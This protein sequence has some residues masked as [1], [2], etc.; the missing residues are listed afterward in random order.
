MMK[1]VHKQRKEHFNENATRDNGVDGVFA[2][3]G[4]KLECEVAGVV[5][6]TLKQRRVCHQCICHEQETRRE[7]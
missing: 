3:D 7:V 2:A 4:N 5:L 1:M 6:D